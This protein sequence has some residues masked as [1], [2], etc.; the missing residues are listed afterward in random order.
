MRAMP[1]REQALVSVDIEASGPSPSVGS[2]LSIG[3]CLIE[4]PE[5][6][7]YVELKPIAGRVWDDS[8]EAIHQLSPDYLEREGLEPRRAME[9]FAE[10]AEAVTAERSAV[11]V[12]F[13]APFDWM[14]VADYLWRYVGRNPFGVSALDLKSYFMGR[15][16][17]EL[18][19]HTRRVDIDAALGVEP[20]HNHHAL[21]DAK[22][23]A[24]LAKVL[25]GRR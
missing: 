20:D 16:G 23:Q 1:V 2:L 9:Q 3:A 14:F 18:W 22:G 8:A 19:Q 10:W 6:D 13:N 24:R 15:D 4:D 25:L 17:V 5:I 21:D 7:F 12:G 11:F